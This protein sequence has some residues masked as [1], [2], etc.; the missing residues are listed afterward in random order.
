M[1]L[2][3]TYQSTKGRVQAQLFPIIPIVKSNFFRIRDQ[4]GIYKPKFSFQALF[5]DCQPTYWFPQIR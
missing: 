1:N 5:S 2:V 3:N 4:P